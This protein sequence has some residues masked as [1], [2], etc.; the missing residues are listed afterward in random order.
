M[1][2]RIHFRHSEYVI[3]KKTLDR[4]GPCGY[5]DRLWCWESISAGPLML[6]KLVKSH[7]STETQPLHLKNRRHN[8]YPAAFL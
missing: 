5:M 4:E 6:V 1:D 7:P 2:L 8:T 3:S